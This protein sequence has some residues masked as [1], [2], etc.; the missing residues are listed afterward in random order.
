MEM[1]FIYCA[2]YDWNLSCLCDE[3]RLHEET[4]SAWW[5]RMKKKE[6][7]QIQIWKVHDRKYPM[8][9]CGFIDIASMRFEVILSTVINIFILSP[10]DC[11]NTW[12]RAATVAMAA[13]AV[14]AAA[15]NPIAKSQRM[16]RFNELYVFFPLFCVYSS[17]WTEL[18]HFYFILCFS[19][20][21][22]E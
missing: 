11:I 3:V 8:S 7:L 19:F 18:F 6:K 2:H 13:M 4:M 9:R 12:A 21:F 14:T 22:Q 16:G 10:I 5:D 1:I 15:A 17:A 20:Y